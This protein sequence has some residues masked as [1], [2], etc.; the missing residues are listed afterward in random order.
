MQPTF[1]IPPIG[2]RQGKLWG[3]TQLVFAWNGVECWGL[4]IKKGGYSST[5]FHSS[6]WNRFYVLSGELKVE[7]LLDQNITDC[8]IIKAGQL[9]DVP[10]GTK[11]RFVALEDSL[12]MEF[13][14]T[15]LE[16]NDIER[17]GS[18]GGIEN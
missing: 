16:A 10:P 18:R 7:I 4:S 8:S 14:W 2:A 5:Y 6:K 3:I 12:V 17:E 1:N 13:Y 15:V 11:H 9:T